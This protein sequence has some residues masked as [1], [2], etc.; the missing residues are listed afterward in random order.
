MSLNAHG[1]A[2]RSGDMNKGVLRWVDTI[3]DHDIGNRAGLE[4]HHRHGG[5]INLDVRVVDVAPLA[6][7]LV[8]LA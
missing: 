3:G 2:I 8:D 1:M 6:I 4:G 7:D 5:V